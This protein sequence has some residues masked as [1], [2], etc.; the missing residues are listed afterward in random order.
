MKPVPRRR[1]LATAAAIAATALIHACGGGGAGG[2]A[3][4]S[5]S[6]IVDGP[7]DA[8]GSIIANGVRMD[9]S[10]AT[11][12][13]DGVVV[14]QADLNVGDSVS[15]QGTLNGDG[16]GVATAVTTDEF[17]KGPLSSV[18][19]AGKSFVAIGQTVLTDSATVFAN[20]TLATLAAGNLVEVHGSLNAND[21][22]LATRVELKTSLTEYEVSGVID[23]STPSTFT[24]N[25]LIVNYAGAAVTTAGSVALAAGMYVNVGATSAPLGGT[26]T[27]TSVRQE[28][29]VRGAQPGAKAE[30]EGQVSQVVSP[31]RFIVR[32]VTVDDGAGT[33]F[34]GGTAA[35]IAQNVKVEVEGSFDSAGVLQAT[36]IEIKQSLD[37]RITTTID[38]V[39]VGA[40]TVT[41][42]GKVFRVNANTQFEDNRDHLSP[43]RLA[44]LSPGDY[45]E[46][47]AYVD[48]SSLVA[49]RIERD[50]NDARLEL[51]GPV[52]SEGINSL[53]IL[54]ITVTTDGGTE[55][56]GRDDGS[57]SSATFYATLAPGDIV[58]I[59]QDS[60]GGAIVADQASIEDED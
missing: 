27:A 33:A 2:V 58:E 14:T 55:F 5:G 29:Q 31:T 30:I 23:A 1:M 10:H 15:M 38:A 52:D 37:V 20:V 57:I 36:R 4:I 11:I 9:I 17:L 22:V 13:N 7:I 16:T 51:R 3:D 44:N 47:R 53:V 56:E 50:S 28:D 25:G 54:G 18:D 24:V 35:S 49:S 19:I 43:F 40:S 12:T 45:V 21:Q 48:G 32:G 8:F 59:R 39:D 26:L 34:D 41:M 46:L 60:P 6:G 42:L